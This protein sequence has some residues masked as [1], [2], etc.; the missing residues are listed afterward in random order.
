[1][2]VY[3]TYKDILRLPRIY[4]HECTCSLEYK[5]LAI[6]ISTGYEPGYRYYLRSPS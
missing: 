3:K 1:M 5:L 2:H 6:S 4:V